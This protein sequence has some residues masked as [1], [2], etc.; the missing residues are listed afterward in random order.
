MEDSFLIY[1]SGWIPRPSTFKPISEHYPPILQLL[2]FI[3]ND[4]TS[5]EQI[6]EPFHYRGC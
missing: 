6:I 1:D 5:K 3:Q 2:S 4:G